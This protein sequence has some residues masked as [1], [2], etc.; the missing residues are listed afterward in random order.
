M[1]A[2]LRVNVTVVA[3]PGRP[4]WCG[5]CKAN[6]GVSVDVLGLFPTGVTRISKVSV[7]EVHDDPDDQEDR[8]G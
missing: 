1:S 4:A 8:R 6:T 2:G 3:G 5:R 7:C